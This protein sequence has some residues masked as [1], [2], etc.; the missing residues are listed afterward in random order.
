MEIVN[1]RL[2]TATMY[3]EHYES[4]DKLVLN[5]TPCRDQLSKMA[6]ELF[7]ERKKLQDSLAENFQ[8]SK[9]LLGKHLFL[10]KQLLRDT[11]DF[12]NFLR[13]FTVSNLSEMAVTTIFM[14]KAISRFVV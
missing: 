6:A 14:L 10:Y 7:T 12:M 13:D 4:S 3:T 1:A 2:I 9:E 8:E 5:G 11:V